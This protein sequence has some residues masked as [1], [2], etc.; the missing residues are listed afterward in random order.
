MCGCLCVRADKH[1]G[2]FVRDSAA[3]PLC[4]L[5]FLPIIAAVRIAKIVA[6]RRGCIA[7]VALPRVVQSWI[8]L[9]LVRDVCGCELVGQIVGHVN[10]VG[11][12]HPQ[13][14]EYGGER[15]IGCAD[16]RDGGEGQECLFH[17]SAPIFSA[18]SCSIISTSSLCSMASRSARSASRLKN[19]TDCS[20]SSARVSAAIAPVSD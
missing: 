9:A 12:S 1:A 11:H 19:R 5:A 6:V 4:R 13:R 16:E 8:F 10:D 14:A 17:R 18:R 15:E 3:T 2:L 20:D 7:V